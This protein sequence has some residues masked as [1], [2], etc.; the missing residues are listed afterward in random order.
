MSAGT[1]VR[2][3]RLMVRSSSCAPVSGGAPIDSLSSACACATRSYASAAMRSASSCV[4]TPSAISRS[5]Y[6]LRTGG[7][8]LILA[9]ICGC[10]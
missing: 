7:C 9:Y 3:S 2:G 6:S 8:V 5:A 4:T 10:V 1:V